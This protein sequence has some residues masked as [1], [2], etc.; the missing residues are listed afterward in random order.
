MSECDGKKENRVRRIN[1]SLE[2]NEYRKID[3]EERV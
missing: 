1:Y 2:S 3:A